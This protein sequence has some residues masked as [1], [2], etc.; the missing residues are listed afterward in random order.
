MQIGVCQ[1]GIWSIAGVEPAKD[2]TNSRVSLRTV[3]GPGPAW[4]VSGAT[5]VGPAGAGAGA[6]WDWA[7]TAVATSQ[8]LQASRKG[9]RLAMAQHLVVVQNSC[10]SQA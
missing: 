2:W 3:R 10:P 7:W 8:A 5:A 6:G 9:R 1:R 4:T